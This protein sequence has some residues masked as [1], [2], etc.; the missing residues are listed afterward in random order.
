MRKLLPRFILP[1]CILLADQLLKS[2]VRTLNSPLPLL[3]G[4]IRLTHAENSG[5]AFS[6]FARA[7]QMLLIVSAIMT[8]VLL[9]FSIWWMKQHPSGLVSIALR[10]MLAG[11]A[12]NLIDRVLF[13]TVTDMFET[14][15]M[16]FAIFNLADAALVVGCVLAFIGILLAPK[17]GSNG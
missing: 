16:R 13:G 10:L 2:Y 3:P 17:E 7:P 14:E 11:A 9:G 8:F 5:A 1:V 4:V 12:G 6:M 15:F